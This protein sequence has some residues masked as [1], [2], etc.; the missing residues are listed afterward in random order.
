[1]A[2]LVSSGRRNNGGDG[3][4]GRS[5]HRSSRRDL[6]PAA[7]AVAPR[8]RRR[9]VPLIASRLRWARGNTPSDAD[10]LHPPHAAVTPAAATVDQLAI[11]RRL[12]GGNRLSAGPPV[13]E[14][15]ATPAAGRAAARMR[16]STFTDIELPSCLAN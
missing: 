11:A 12:Q 14:R 16:S 1:M 6:V 9:V 15:A 5:R 10:L 4:A 7:Y 3:E 8:V 2:S 13:A